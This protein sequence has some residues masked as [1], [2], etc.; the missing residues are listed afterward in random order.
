MIEERSEQIRAMFNA[1]LTHPSGCRV[2][3][4]PVGA[5]D[6]QPESIGVSELVITSSDFSESQRDVGDKRK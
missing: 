5:D 2:E 3:P 4:Q 6:P 1:C